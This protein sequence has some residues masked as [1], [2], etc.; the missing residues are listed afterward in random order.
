[1]AV[2]EA[3]RMN[4]LLDCGVQV[5]VFEGALLYCSRAVRGSGREREAE[6][7][8]DGKCGRGG[9]AH[10][11]LSISTGTLTGRW[12]SG[13]GREQTRGLHSSPSSEV[14]VVHAFSGF[15]VMPMNNSNS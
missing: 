15:H 14:A 7:A 5:T 3:H 6:Q 4:K 12:T 2:Y 1:M 9:G 11:A 13:L 8:R 10:A